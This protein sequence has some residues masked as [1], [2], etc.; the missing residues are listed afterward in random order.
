MVL[1]CH[2]QLM[3]NFILIFTCIGGSAM[4]MSIISRDGC[5]NMAEDSHY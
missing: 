3:A 5:E 2:A 1:L 4:G